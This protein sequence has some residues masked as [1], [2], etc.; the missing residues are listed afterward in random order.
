MMCPGI[1]FITIFVVIW[2]EIIEWK[3]W[4][5]TVAKMKAFSFFSFI[6][7]LKIHKMKWDLLYILKKMNFSIPGLS[8]II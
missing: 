5:N 2:Y 1:E 3:S 8:V 6:I 7:H 4:K